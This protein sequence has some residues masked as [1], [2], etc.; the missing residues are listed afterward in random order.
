MFTEYTLFKIT[1]TTTTENNPTHLY[2]D[3]F[4]T[5]KTP[6]DVKNG[7]DTISNKIGKMSSIVLS[8]FKGKQFITSLNSSVSTVCR[9]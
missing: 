6:E 4:I 9:N 1:F 7:L 3:S 2:E 8:R 5:I